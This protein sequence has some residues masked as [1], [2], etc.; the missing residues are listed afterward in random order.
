MGDQTRL[1]V[2]IVGAGASGLSAAWELARA[3]HQVEVFE[4]ERTVGGLAA[5]F[6]DDG[7]EWFL[8]KFYHHWF[9]TDHAILALARELGV[10]DQVMFRRAR[11]S[12]LID[13]RR[14][15]SE[16]NLSALRLP[17][18]FGARLRQALVGA[19]LKYLTRDWHALEQF[20]ADAWLR[21]HMGDEVYR[22]LWAPLLVAK[23]GDRY[24]DVNMA[25][26]WAR[27]VSRSLRL[28]TYRGGF[29]A[30]LDH[31]A[32]ALRQAGTSLRLSTPVTR[33]GVS[34]GRPVLE[35]HGEIRSFDRV[36]STVSPSL[37]LR[38]APE[39]RATDYGRQVSGLESCGA[40]SVVLALRQSLLT[41]GTYWL[42][43]PAASMDRRARPLPFQ[44]GDL[45]EEVVDGSGGMLG[46]HLGE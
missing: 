24:L 36:I 25:W 16:M 46:L 17:V 44:R 33:I 4:A 35:V 13:G 30:L 12:S 7:W 29:Q 31:L 19:Y 11:T 3:G 2:G 32:A 18:S 42:N 10:R 1:A 14:Y 5:G 20:T 15:A 22:T 38:L 26:V 23:F 21:R 40:I 9:A 28:G 41:D 27:I 45:A 8:E 34:N 37:M 39:L 43:V 6:R